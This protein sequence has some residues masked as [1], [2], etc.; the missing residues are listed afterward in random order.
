MINDI[1]INL[2]KSKLIMI[3]TKINKDECK[4]IV[5]R[6]EVYTTK[7]KEAVRF[8]GIWIGQ[9]VGKKQIIVKAKQVVRLFANTIKKKIVSTSQILYINNIYLILKLEYILQNIFLTKDKYEKIQQLYVMTAK[10][11]LGL[12]KILPNFVI[13]HSGILNMRTL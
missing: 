2:S 11:K 5:D 8:L 13:S 7:E 6:Q 12:T 4:I 1:Q 9:K 3:N 10:N